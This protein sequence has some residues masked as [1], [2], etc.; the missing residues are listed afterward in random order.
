MADCTAE[1]RFRRAGYTT[2]KQK[3]TRWWEVID[4]AGE[5]VCLTV[6]RRGAREV[7]RRL[8]A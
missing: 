3:D 2:R 5:L 4:P 6:Y 1:R 8:A 7:A